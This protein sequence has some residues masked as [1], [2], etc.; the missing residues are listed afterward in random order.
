MAEETHRPERRR[1]GLR[2]VSGTTIAV[3]S[4]ALLGAAAIVTTP[5]WL[6]Y[7][8]KRK[9]TDALAHQSGSAQAVGQS[10]GDPSTPT[11]G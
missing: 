11:G 7:R 8:R 5:L 10:P 9:R 4:L 3:T 1:F 6:W 2:D